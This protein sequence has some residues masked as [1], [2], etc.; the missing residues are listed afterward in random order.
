MK[1]E[2][3][4]PELQAAPKLHGVITRKTVLFMSPPRAPQ[5]PRAIFSLLICS[6]LC[7]FTYY[8]KPVFVFHAVKYS[9]LPMFQYVQYCRERVLIFLLSA[10]SIAGNGST[11]SPCFRDNGHMVLVVVSYGCRSLLTCLYAKST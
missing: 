11:M 5:I 1:A 2:P 8:F 3:A 10:P 6:S 4:S 9:T 7:C